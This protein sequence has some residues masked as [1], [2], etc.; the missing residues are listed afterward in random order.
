MHGPALSNCHPSPCLNLHPRGW[1]CTCVVQLHA[2]GC[3]G[4]PAQPLSACPS[5]PLLSVFSRQAWHG[6]TLHTP[7]PLWKLPDLP[8]LSRLCSFL[9]P[10]HLHSPGCSITFY[11]N[12]LHLPG[13]G[14]SLALPAQRALCAGAP[15]R[16]ATGAGLAVPGPLLNLMP[17][18]F[19]FS[20]LNDTQTLTPW[21][22]NSLFPFRAAQARASAVPLLPPNLLQC[23]RAVLPFPRKLQTGRPLLL[24]SL[25]VGRM[26]T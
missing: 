22:H 10:P 21:P 17:S 12:Q 9:P 11:R 8:C 3:P 24:L 14:S 5:W 13:K 23:P 2:R 15:G 18:P 4:D 25:R 7:A 26:S 6:Q 1:L 19:P 20:P 16:N